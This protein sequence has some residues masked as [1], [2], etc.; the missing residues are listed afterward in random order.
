MST[1]ENAVAILRCFTTERTELGVSRVSQDLG[2][3]KSTV[4]RL[5]KQMAELGLLARDAE[6]RRYRAGYLMFQLGSLYQA[7]LR[8]FDLVDEC[9]LRLVAATGHTGFIGVLDKG[10]LVSLRTHQGAHPVRYV[11]ETGRRF[12]AFAASLGKALLARLSDDD[13]RAFYPQRLESEFLPNPFTLDELIAELAVI[14]ECGWAD[15]QVGS[16]PG[17]R[18]VGV[19]IG[20]AGR[21]QAIGFSLSYREASVTGLQREQ[22]LATILGAARDIGIRTGDPHWVGEW[23]L[24]AI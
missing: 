21:Q 2:V 23:K 3:A 24:R 8:I 20:G 17:A 6:S 9:V 15:A 16:I 18:A 5:M 22:I 14:R 10:D 11:L 19:A 1:L 7:D 13:V 4:S 12:P